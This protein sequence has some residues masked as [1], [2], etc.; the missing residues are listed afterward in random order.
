MTSIRT[1]DGDSWVQPRYWYGAGQRWL[2]YEPSVTDYPTRY[3]FDTDDEGWNPDPGSF[4]APGYMEMNTAP[5]A[6]YEYTYAYSPYFARHVSLGTAYTAQ[7]HVSLAAATGA[8]PEFGMNVYISGLT[9]TPSVKHQFTYVGES[10]ALYMPAYTAEGMLLM[11][12]IQCV[13]YSD[14]NCSSTVRIDYCELSRSDG[15]PITETKPAKNIPYYWD[16]AAW[17]GQTEA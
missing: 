14:P 3:T 9:D 13:V 4:W 1:F 7:V 5:S 8:L 10:V 15:S 6:A 12:N 17:R 16:G 2:E 11:P